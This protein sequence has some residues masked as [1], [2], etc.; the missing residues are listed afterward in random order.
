MALQ[1]NFF[2]FNGKIHK[3]T[4][5]AAMGSSLDPILAYAFLCFREQ[6]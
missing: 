1:N 4:D 5:G 6:I 3:Q 2:N